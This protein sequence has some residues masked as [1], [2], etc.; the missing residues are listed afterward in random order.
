MA[1]LAKEPFRFYTRQNLTLLSG[2][3]ASNLLE[4]LKGIKEAPDMS[5]YHHTHHYLEQHEFLS[6]EPPNDFAYWVSYVLQDKLLGEEIASLDLRQYSS[7]NEIRQRIIEIIEFSVG[8][9]N[10]SLSRN[11]PIGEEFHFMIARSFVF[12]TKYTAINLIE[13][14]ECLKEVSINS[15]FY[16]VFE[17]R[18]FKKIPGFCEWLLS[19]LDEKELSEKICKLDPYTQTMENLRK[20]II[21]LVETKLKDSYGT[22]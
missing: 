7:I 15:I 17:A 4:L 13:F 16:H 9:S 12:P 14:F 21:G 20:M 22:A 3:K 19:S 5:I 8:Q 1:L 10:E 6:P 18:L 2:K 11:S